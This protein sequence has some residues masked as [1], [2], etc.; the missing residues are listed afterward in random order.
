MVDFALKHIRNAHAATSA[1]SVV[2]VV[3]SCRDVITGG[4]ILNALAVFFFQQAAD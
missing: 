4:D 3:F 1:V 2:G